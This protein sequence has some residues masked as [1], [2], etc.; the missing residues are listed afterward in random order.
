MVVPGRV[1]WMRQVMA[2]EPELSRPAP[3]AAF[4]ELLPQQMEGAEHEEFRSALA[5]AFTY[6]TVY[7]TL[8]PTIV[9]AAEQVRNC[10]GP[11]VGGIAGARPRS[12][13]R[14][15]ITRPGQTRC[16]EAPG[17]RRRALSARA[18]GRFA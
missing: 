13:G 6:D 3:L 17:Q 16:R 10:C 1:E 7:R 11:M 4:G 18:G 2:R 9:A 8:R 15:Q 14:G 5:P 12:G